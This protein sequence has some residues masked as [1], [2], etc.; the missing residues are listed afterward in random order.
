M[1]TLACLTSLQRMLCMLRHRA[2]KKAYSFRASILAL[3][4]SDEPISQSYGREGL[5]CH[6]VM[7]V[8]MSTQIKSYLLYN[9]PNCIPLY[10]H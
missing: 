4:I 8:S 9:Y 3:M 2:V 6:P 1:E 7:L 5:F 10:F